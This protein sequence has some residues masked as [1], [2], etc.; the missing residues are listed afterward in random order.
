MPSPPSAAAATRPLTRMLAWWDA[1][2]SGRSVILAWIVSRLVVVALLAAA[3]RLVVGDVFY[4]W[5]KIEALFTV[6]LP[7]TLNEYPTPVVWLLWLPYGLTGGTRT[8]YLIA[9]VLVMVVLDAAFACALWRA[10]GRRHRR[11]LDFWVLYPFLVGPL[12]YT[13]FDMIPAVLAGG[14][15]LAARRRPALT[16]ALTG[17]GAAVKLWP[18]LLIAAFAAPRRGRP[19]VLAGFAVAG[20]GLA[21]LSLALGGWVRLFSPLTWQSGRG[22]QIES[23]WATPLMLARMVHPQGWPVTYS[24]FQ[25][26]EVFG[27]GVGA[28]LTLSTVAT[29][30]GLVMIGAL[31]LR[32]FRGGGAVSA[33]AVGL[34]VLAVVAIMTITNKTLSPQY[35]LWMGGPA[36]ALLVLR[37]TAGPREQRVITRLAG[38][39]LILAVLTHLVYPLLYNGL[40]GR[41]GTGLLVGATTVTALRNLALV[42]FTV[43][44]CRYAWAALRAPRVP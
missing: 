38:Q 10:A 32:A 11:S 14:A 12:C 34:L 6:G 19:L 13:R 26:Y 4:Y 3:E 31:S 23:V 37:P 29:I 30:A 33:V 5:R 9:F 40:L 43:E 18:A 35:L 16:G 41:T 42:S 2:R 15:M 7:Q 17:I 8:G 20:C 21:G 44:V 39:L 28:L 36:A 27:P 22:L 25:A 1:R 24:R